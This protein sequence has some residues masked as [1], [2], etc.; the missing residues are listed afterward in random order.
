MQKIQGFL[1]FLTTCAVLATLPVAC[2]HPPET[3][4]CRFG[5]HRDRT[6]DIHEAVAAWLRDYPTEKR[7]AEMTQLAEQIVT[8]LE[9]GGSLYLAG[10]SGFCDELDDRAG[11]LP[12]ANSWN[13]TQRMTTN[14]VLLV[15]F[16]DGSSKAARQFKPAFIGQNNGRFTQAL[17]VVIGSARW[18]LVEKMCGIADPARWQAGL[19]LLDTDVPAARDMQSCAVSQAATIAT[20]CALEGEMIAAASRRGKT[21]AFYPSM[22]APGGSEYGD[23]IKGR[24]FLDEPKVAP[25][26]AGH[27]ARE[28]FKTCREQVEAFVDSDQPAQV[29]KAA[30][31]MADCQQRGGTIFT[32]TWGH[33]LQRGAT[34]PPE[35]ERLAL[36]SAAWSWKSPQGLKTN[37]LLCV[38]GYLDYPK[39]EVDG[40]RSN[41]VAAVTLSVAGGPAVRPDVTD[42]QC[43]WKAYDG[44][45]EVPGYRYKALA[46]SG[47][48]MTAVWYSLM[49]EARALVAAPA[50]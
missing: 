13:V 11:G 27:M 9:A 32:V 4:C 8:R 12:F 10:E 42:I 37:D 34:V 17:T 5:H 36:Y 22:F 19:H 40:A 21:L 14:D 45:V 50:P 33:V 31:W 29:R 35:L 46:S 24:V 15:G 41:G 28:Y 39:A 26:A 7:V 44:C 47:V 48:V 25:V 6:E 23:K 38:F 2:V 30:Q 49:D 20:A 18:P 3:T 43:F 16:F 1:K